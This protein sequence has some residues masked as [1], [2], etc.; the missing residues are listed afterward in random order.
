MQSNQSNWQQSSQ[1]R[2]FMEVFSQEETL[3]SLTHLLKKVETIEE[4]IEKIADSLKKIPGM[5]SIA[6][7]TLDNEISGAE[8]R[9]TDLDE[10]L[11]QIGMLVERL[12]E[13]EMLMKLNQVVDLADS[14]PGLVSIVVDAVDDDINVLNAAGVTVDQRLKNL[15]A[16]LDGISQP[17]VEKTL[18][19]LLTF[20]ERMPDTLAMIADTVDDQMDSVKDK[21]LDP[22]EIA[23]FIA[24]SGKALST[25]QRNRI[26]PVGGIFS[27]MKKIKDPDRQKAI[28][29]LMD[30]LKSFGMEIEKKSKKTN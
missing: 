29:F 7:D 6:T 17:G 24:L 21:G 8:G 3:K 4:S 26:Q 22:Q 10:R 9:S 25:T 2:E 14:L 20:A 11:Q 15:A 16:I 5:V 28:G 23:S 13:P 12:T 30:F 27:I 1:G 19:D 18:N